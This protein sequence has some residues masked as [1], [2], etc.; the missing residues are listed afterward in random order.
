MGLSL[1]LWKGLGLTEGANSGSS[2]AFNLAEN[3][4]GSSSSLPSAKT[5][6]GVLVHSAGTKAKLSI[7]LSIVHKLS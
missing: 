1:N 3:K 6:D 5:Y 4:Y 2:E 7:Y